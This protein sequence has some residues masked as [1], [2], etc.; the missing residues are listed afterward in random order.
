MKLK[1]LLA[2]SLF[3]LSAYAQAGL[4][5]HTFDDG[6]SLA[7]WGKDRCAPAG[8]DI[9]GGELVMSVGQSA[10]A[11]CP[12]GAFYL[13]Q[14]MKLD[15]GSANYLSIEMYVDADN[16]LTDGRFG[17]IWGVAYN[18]SDAIS[19]YPILEYA[20]TNGTGGIQG[21]HNNSINW[22]PLTPST[23]NLNAFNTFAFSIKSGVIN[24]FI[25]GEEVFNSPLSGHS[26]FGE[27]IL[28]A[29][30]DGTDYQVRYDN[31]TYGTVPE[32]ASLAIMGAGLLLLGARRA[33][34][35]K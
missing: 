10:Q 19:F 24:Y 22:E 34:R 13:T 26:Y 21:W 16:W 18:D 25:N 5:T 29:K 1:S 6:D 7:D 32:P 14:G 12:A 23:L 35:A 8:F 17:G 20:V 33:R 31:L 11:A 27:V 30:N 9:S 2:V 28:N 3:T 4:V 15:L